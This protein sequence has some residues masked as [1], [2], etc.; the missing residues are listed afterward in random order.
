VL[1]GFAAKYSITYPLLSDEGSHV[2]RAF[3]LYNEHLKEQA[4]F[5][6]REA[7]PDQFGVPYPGVFRL[8][9]Q[10]IVVGKVFEQSYRVRPAPALLLEDLAAAPPVPVALIHRIEREG[11]TIT[12]GVDADSYRP[13]EKHELHVTL[14]MAP[15]V[16]IY[17]TSVPEGFTPLEVTIAPFDGLDVGQAELPPPHPL[18]IEGIDEEFL[19][20][21]GAV[22][23][24]VPFDLVPFQ[25]TAT[26]AV[27]VRYQAC[28]DSL[29][30]PPDAATFE[31]TLRGVVLIRE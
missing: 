14:E 15:G 27:E 6:G 28:T 30:Y 5:Y 16:H 26:L 20:Y 25:E 13:Y 10:G 8:D 12:V 31:L 4:L 22:E 2:I 17:G 3:G 11:V 18:R 23:A 24:V 21:N 1:A 9:E 29:C 19:V 7:R